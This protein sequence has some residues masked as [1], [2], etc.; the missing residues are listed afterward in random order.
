MSSITYE[1][2]HSPCKHYLWCVLAVGWE[3]CS[4]SFCDRKAKPNP[5]LNGL[6]VAGAESRTGAVERQSV[7]PQDP[8]TC[9]S[10]R[11]LLLQTRMPTPVRAMARTMDPAT[12]F[13]TRG[14][15]SDSESKKMRKTP[16]VFLP[17][18]LNFGRLFSLWWL[19]SSTLFFLLSLLTS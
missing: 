5:F 16:Q 6:R 13:I 19:G 7:V 10:P 17:V 15:V 3:R 8:S 4:R 12:A 1:T 18:Y 2:D 9:L 14:I 11:G